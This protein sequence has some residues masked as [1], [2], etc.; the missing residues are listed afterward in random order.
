MEV[1]SPPTPPN[2]LRRLLFVGCLFAG[3]AALVHQTGVHTTTPL[4]HLFGTG[5]EPPSA[6]PA[7]ST[8]VQ[9]RVLTAAEL[10]QYRGLPGQPGCY[11][12]VLG[13]VYDVAEG[14]K[15]YGPGQTYHGFAGVSFRRDGGRGRHDAARRT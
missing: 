12:A 10:L 6:T 5:T 8:G 4:R 14:I 2:R 1:P 11:V 15:H 13:R 9:Q 3:V 7:T